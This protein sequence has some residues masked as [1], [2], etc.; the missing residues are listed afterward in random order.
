M[1]QWNHLIG[2]KVMMKQLKLILKENDHLVVPNFPL[3]NNYFHKKVKLFFTFLYFFFSIEKKIKMWGVY[4][5]IL[6]FYI[7][8]LKP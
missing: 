8:H 5:P 6:C 4:I 7:L 3:P 2:F 1:N